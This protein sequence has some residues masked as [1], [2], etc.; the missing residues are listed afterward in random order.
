MHLS[1]IQEGSMQ[2]EIKLL[3]LYQT[4]I[5]QYIGEEGCLLPLINRG[6]KHMKKEELSQLT[7]L[8][9]EIELIKEQINDVEF[10]VVTDSVKGSSSEY[11]YTQH[12]IKI[13]GID[14]R[15]YNRKVNKLKMQ[16]SQKLSE[17][18]DKV[19]EINDY[20][21]TIDDSEIRMILTLRYIN[22]LPWHQVAAHMGVQGD[23]ST[24]RK[25][26]DRFMKLS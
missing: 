17:L 26:H 4:V 19:T 21:S 25:K 16:L 15:D 22:N 5:F 1:Y 2:V 7:S 9:K 10:S 3:E 13:Q 11:P 24:E 23:G 18:M 14:Y 6:D 12:S 20:I 8:N